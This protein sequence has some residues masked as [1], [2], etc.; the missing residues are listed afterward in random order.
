MSPVAGVDAQPRDDAG[1]GP[2]R[3]R[4]NGTSDFLL[5]M[6]PGPSLRLATGIGT[7]PIYGEATDSDLL[8]VAACRNKA[9]TGARHACE[10][11]PHAPLP[12]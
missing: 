7:H 8:M 11:A 6:I 3:G 9:D 4:R 2:A 10:L 5:P 12:L 1:P